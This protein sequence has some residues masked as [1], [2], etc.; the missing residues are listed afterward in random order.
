[1]MEEH[2]LKRSPKKAK[3]TTTTLKTALHPASFFEFFCQAKPFFLSFIGHFSDG[4]MAGSMY[5]DLTMQ[6]TTVLDQLPGEREIYLWLE[7]PTAS[8]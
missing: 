3:K 8:F 6:Q 4:R 2:D 7:I 1:M 5:S